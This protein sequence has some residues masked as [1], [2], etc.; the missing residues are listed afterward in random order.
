MRMTS[1]LALLV[2]TALAACHEPEQPKVPPHPTNPTNGP[3]VPGAIAARANG[4]PDASIVYDAAP[5]LDVTAFAHD[6]T[7]FQAPSTW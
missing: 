2:M 5:Q 4:T 1:S 6:A 7:P 3:S